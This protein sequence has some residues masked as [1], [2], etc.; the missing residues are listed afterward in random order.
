M[1]HAG[2]TLPVPIMLF[3]LLKNMVF[4][5][6]CGFRLREYFVATPFIRAAMILYPTPYKPLVLKNK[7]RNNKE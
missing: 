7:F 2:F 1:P 6:G 4:L 5:W 3:K